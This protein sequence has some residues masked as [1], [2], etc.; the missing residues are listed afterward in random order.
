VAHAR[1]NT[2]ISS[3]ELPLYFAEQVEFL[4]GPGSTLYG[5]SAYF[6]VI[7]I[8][9]KSI[10][11]DG[12]ISEF[13]S[14]FGNQDSNK[15]FMANV[16]H[17]KEGQSLTFNMGYYD[18]DPSRDFVGQTNNTQYL[19]YDDK[20]DIFLRGQYQVNEGSL[21]GIEAGVMYLESRGGLGEFWSHSVF[22]HEVM[23]LTWETIVPY[24]RY[25][26]TLSDSTQFNSYL[27]NNRSN[28]FG[29]TF[30]GGADEFENFNGEDDS[31]LIYEVVVESW[32]WQSEIQHKHSPTSS[33]ILGLN[34]ETRNQD[35]ETFF[36]K[37][38]SSATTEAIYDSSALKPDRI[39]TYSIYGQYQNELDFLS[40]LIITTG[41]RL[42]TSDSDVATYE[43]LSP[44]LSL[45]QKLNSNWNIKAQLGQALRAPGLQE[46]GLNQQIIKKYQDNNVSLN[47]DAIE[48]EIITTSEIGLTYSKDNVSAFITY[49]SNKTE[50]TI[51][52][53]VV[54]DNEEDKVYINA[55]GTIEAEGLEI[56]VHYK[57]SPH[58]QILSNY[59][60]A[61][62]KDVENTE[63]ND[64][65]TGK[66]NMATSYFNDAQSTT[67]I[68]RHIDGFQNSESETYNDPSGYQV[69]DLNWVTNLTSTA[70][71]ELQIRNLL[72]ES[73]NIPKTKV[74]YQETIDELGDI[75]ITSRNLLMSFDVKF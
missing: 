40:G 45:V 47:L 28:Q 38:R 72:D 59:S 30:L 5:S 17:R 12:A 42:D 23:D 75:S 62:S 11:K 39:N 74:T 71:L 36:Y 70:K 73:Y 6:G 9:P 26:N 41:A 16:Y 25:K 27:K 8:K 33:S 20:K 61:Q 35:D 48:P 67:L 34:I 2:A 31:F 63:L 53:E 7:S 46:A 57:P 37:I 32:A 52:K 13:K 50:H 10:K 18:K 60:M 19:N 65:P 43:Q 55:N 15:R 1:A 22:S 54:Q 4:R 3:E 24:L 29:V 66:F 64:I 21:S 69:I 44:R 14:S 58:W 68:I 51:E 56:E 49:F